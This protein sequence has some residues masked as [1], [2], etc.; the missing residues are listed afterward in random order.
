VV[1]NGFEKRSLAA[2]VADE[3]QKKILKGD[4]KPGERLLGEKLAKELDVSRGPIRDAFLI[5][6]K[7]GLV[8]NIPY[9][10][11]SVIEIKKKDAEEVCSLR[12]LLEEYAIKLCTQNNINSKKTDQIR[13]LIAKKEKAY[14]E[15]YMINYVNLGCNIHK[16]IIDIPGHQLLSQV[17]TLIK[18]KILLVEAITY[19]RRKFSNYAEKYT[20]AQKQI[21]QAIEEKNNELA[22]KMSKNIYKWWKQELNELYQDKE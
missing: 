4:I 5:L 7:I 6:E 17:F 14:Q 1:N 10:G 13:E 20:Y 9:K 16:K 21:V 19:R 11:A 2:Q 3:I 22:L 8:N 15:N 12:E 18:G